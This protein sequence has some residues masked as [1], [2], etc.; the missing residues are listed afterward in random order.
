MA[1]SKTKKPSE[2]SKVAMIET[3]IGEAEKIL[4][5]VNE[6]TILEYAIYLSSMDIKLDDNGI[7][8]D[9]NRYD[10]DTKELMSIVGKKEAPK[11]IKAKLPRAR[12]AKSVDDER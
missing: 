6:K 9:G 1:N 11:G 7:D 4:E 12:K 8:K 10:L 2:L 3:K 5:E